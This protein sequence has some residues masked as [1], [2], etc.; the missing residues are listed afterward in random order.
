MNVR[1]GQM[2]GFQHISGFHLGGLSVEHALRKINGGVVAYTLEAL[3]KGQAQL[4]CAI[5]HVLKTSKGA[6]DERP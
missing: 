3:H 2:A 6:N 1:T 5:F 4:F